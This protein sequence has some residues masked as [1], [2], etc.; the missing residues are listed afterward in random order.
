MPIAV[1]PIFPTLIAT[2]QLD[3]Y[4]KHRPSLQKA[5]E[6]DKE[7]GQWITNTIS[8]KAFHSLCPNE[9]DEDGLNASDGIK[10]NLKDFIADLT[11]SLD[12][13]I[14]IMVLINLDVTGQR[15]LV[16]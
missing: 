15:C 3:N 7:S 16:K 11:K 8:D 2:G 4:R 6:E 5:Y 1:Q 14:L 10:N 12:L 9:K 13:H